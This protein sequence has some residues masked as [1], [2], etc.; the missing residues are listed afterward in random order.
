MRSNAIKEHLDYI[1][2]VTEGDYAERILQYICIC[3]C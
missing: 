2:D 1:Y 3:G